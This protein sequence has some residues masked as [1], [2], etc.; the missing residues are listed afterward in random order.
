MV[1]IL[2]CIPREKIFHPE[3]SGNCVNID[4]LLNTCD[5]F[6]VVT[7]LLILLL[8]VRTVWE[9]DLGWV[10]KAGVWAVLALGLWYIFLFSF[11]VKEERD[12]C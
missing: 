8:P 12:M 7:D 4:V 11:S 10:K 6:D 1:K 5:A 2:E 9:L 3:V